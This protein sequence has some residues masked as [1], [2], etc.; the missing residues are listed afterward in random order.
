MRPARSCT[1]PARRPLAR[2]RPGTEAVGPCPQ[3]RQD[4]PPPT[5]RRAAKRGSEAEEI[6]DV[7][8]KDHRSAAP[9]TASLHHTPELTGV[10]PL[11]HPRVLLIPVRVTSEA[12]NSYAQGISAMQ[13]RRPFAA[14]GLLAQKTGQRLLA[15][16]VPLSTAREVARLRTPAAHDVHT[17]PAGGALTPPPH[18]R[19]ARTPQIER[20][21]VA[22]LPPSD[23]EVIP[24]GCGVSR[25]VLPEN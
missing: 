25:P 10:A 23:D 7:K 13:W 9:S 11:G 1:P 8:N 16:C 3:F 14:Q 20:K 17:R 6:S 21:C 24:A 18:G 5:L 12:Q 22:V 19:D 2:A 4:P 15:H